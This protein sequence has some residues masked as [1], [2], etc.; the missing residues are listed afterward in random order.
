MTARLAFLSVWLSATFCLSSPTITSK[1]LFAAEQRKFVL[2]NSQEHLRVA[3]NSAPASFLR[4]PQFSSA[5]CVGKVHLR[6]CTA[7]RAIPLRSSVCRSSANGVQDE[8]AIAA[9]EVTT[10]GKRGRGIGKNLMNTPVYK[11]T[12]KGMNTSK[13]QAF[14]GNPSEGGTSTVSRRKPRKRRGRGIGKPTEEELAAAELTSPLIEDDSEVSVDE[15]LE[16]EWKQQAG[17]VGSIRPDDA[18]SRPPGARLRSR[19]RTDTKQTTAREGSGEGKQGLGPAIRRHRDLQMREMLRRTSIVTKGVEASESMELFVNPGFL[20][21]RNKANERSAAADSRAGSVSL[22]DLKRLGLVDPAVSAQDIRRGNG[23]VI[24]E[25]DVGM[26]IFD[27]QVYGDRVFSAGSDERITVWNATTWEQIGEMNGH[28]AWVNALLVD[29]ER[30]MLFSA[31]DDGT[32]RGWDLGSLECVRVLKGHTK[33]ALSVSVHRGS[34]FVGCN[35][36]IVVWDL[37]EWKLKT[38]LLNHTHVLRAMSNGQQMSKN[39]Q[40]APIAALA[41]EP[42]KLY[43]HKVCGVQGFGPYLLSAVDDGSVWVWNTQNMEVERKLLGPS[44]PNTWVRPLVI[45]EL[46]DP[47]RKN[48]RT[49]LVSGWADGAI[50]VYDLRTWTLEHTLRAHNGPILSLSQFGDKL[51]STGADMAANVWNSESWTVEQSLRAHNGAVCAAREVDGKLV[52]ASLDGLIKIWHK[53]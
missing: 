11:Q 45:A 31:S 48:A 38:K 39:R 8:S 15:E 6:A 30:G 20:E 53:S 4:S 14:L 43:G 28:T 5:T 42:S 27:M 24:K 50:R 2:E 25:I 9:V 26:A 35:G 37:A 47:R 22:L 52:T 12:E 19:L 34:M 44:V 23:A 29:E 3:F 17:R 51:I 7:S 49:K 46:Q 33:G 36:K 10:R 18:R 1:S 13:S 21:R 41:R 16:D 40:L 32:V